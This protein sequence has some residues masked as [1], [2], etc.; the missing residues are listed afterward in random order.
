MQ[1]EI[2]VEELIVTDSCLNS[3]DR[4]NPNDL[5]FWANYLFENPDQLAVIKEAKS[6]IAE[7]KRM[8]KDEQKESLR[9]PFKATTQQCDQSRNSNL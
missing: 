5:L 1:K 7:M 6:F 9:K 3:C 4:K 2:S 8:L